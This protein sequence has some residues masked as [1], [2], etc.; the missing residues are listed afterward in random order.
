MLWY[1]FKG[2]EARSKPKKC[3]SNAI[4]HG[5]SLLR[6]L[7]YYQLR[8]W[9]DTFGVDRIMVLLSDNFFRSPV[10]ATDKAINYVSQHHSQ[11]YLA[12]A[13]RQF[14]RA[15]QTI[16]ASA[17]NATLRNS[18]TPQDFHISAELHTKLR[19]VYKPYNELLYKLLDAYNIAYTRFT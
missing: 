17:K 2:W 3:T 4:N 16:L 9:I 8:E 14:K 7:Y 15:E 11:S 18:R 19:E 12:A 5:T 10:E 13:A 6:G 1:A